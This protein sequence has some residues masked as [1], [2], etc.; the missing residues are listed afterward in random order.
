VDTFLG[1]SIGLV[2]LL[3]Q[4]VGLVTGWWNFIGCLIFIGHF[5]PK[6]PIISGSFAER[7]PHLTASTASSPPCSSLG[8]ITQSSPS[9]CRYFSSCPILLPSSPVSLISSCISQLVSLFMLD[10]HLIGLLT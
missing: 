4:S 6:S 8:R 3:V 9:V 7:D 1:S 5:P 2:L 10:H